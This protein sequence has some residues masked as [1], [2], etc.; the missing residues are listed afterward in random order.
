M[1]EFQFS[2]HEGETAMLDDTALKVTA[3]L[4]GSKGATV[5][6]KCVCCFLGEGKGVAHL[7]GQLIHIACLGSRLLTLVWLL[8]SL[9]PH[10]TLLQSWK[11]PRLLGL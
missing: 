9:E 3:P 11:A 1:H 6:K 7:L 5:N 10:L 2:M 4:V 8:G